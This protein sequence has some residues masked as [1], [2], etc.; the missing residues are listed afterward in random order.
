[1]G[2]KCKAEATRLRS[3][4]PLMLVH[5]QL[6]TLLG[7]EE[8]GLIGA[9]MTYSDRVAYRLKGVRAE[10]RAIEQRWGSSNTGCKFGPHWPLP[11][12][13]QAETALLNAQLYESE[14]A[15]RRLET[16][17]WQR[18]VRTLPSDAKAARYQAARSADPD[19]AAL[20]DA[21]TRLA[22]RHRQKRELE[23]QLAGARAEAHG[24][25]AKMDGVQGE[26][27]NIQ[28]EDG[29]AAQQMWWL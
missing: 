12:I 23:L 17:L 1:M 13:I 2:E 4:N 26:Y 9:L 14:A 11:P 19:F 6:T 15:I 22:V 27:A 18:G 20:C 3:N 28:A 25:F 16:Q 5:C 10:I 8:R 7:V 24:I 21:L 29:L